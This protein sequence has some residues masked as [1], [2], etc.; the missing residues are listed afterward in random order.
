MNA[1]RCTNCYA[2]FSEQE[3]ATITGG[4]PKCGTESL[5]MDPAQDIMLPINWHE[6]RVLTMWASRWC[7]SNKMNDHTI[8]MFNSLLKRL[9]KHRPAGGAGLTLVEEFKELQQ[10]HPNAELLDSQGNLIVGPK[11]TPNA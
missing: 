6:L 10:E 3:L 11:E 5:P 9:R 8:E 7:D 4:C 2:E 1:A